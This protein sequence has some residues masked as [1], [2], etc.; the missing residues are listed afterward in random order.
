[1]SGRERRRH[2]RVK[3]FAELISCQLRHPKRDLSSYRVRLLDISLGGARLIAPAKIRSRL[4]HG[5]RVRLVLRSERIAKP[6]EVD[7]E[8]LHITGGSGAVRLSLAFDNWVRERKKLDV[9]LL[10]LF[11]EREA[12]RVQPPRA[13]ELTLTWSDGEVEDEGEAP[14]EETMT[15]AIRDL[16]LMGLGIR[17]KPNEAA[18]L[19][20]GMAM[21]AAFRM[22]DPPR[23]LMRCQARVSW[24]MEVEPRKLWF[25]G[26]AL[27]YSQRHNPHLYRIL[28]QFVMNRQIDLRRRGVQG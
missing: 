20:E 12:F 4:S 15:V 7:A 13:M 2:Y 11:N 8:V 9:S 3:D 26:I 17:M 27:D 16:S 25:V 23:P 24:R 22:P 5:D 1:M 18:R 6:V 19:Q 10:Q 21:R 28:N 14:T